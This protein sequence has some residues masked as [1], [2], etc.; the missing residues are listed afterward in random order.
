MQ[1][2]FRLSSTSYD[3][4][5]AKLSTSVNFLMSSYDNFLE[6]K[7]LK[8]GSRNKSDLLIWIRILLIN[9]YP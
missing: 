3:N 9:S 8:V 4:F 2:L 7:K 5:L 1:S 6:K